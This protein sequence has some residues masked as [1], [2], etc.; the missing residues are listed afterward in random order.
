MRWGWFLLAVLV[1]VLGLWGLGILSQREPTSRSRLRVL[2]P[3]ELLAAASKAVLWEQP[4]GKIALLRVPSGGAW[5]SHPTSHH[6]VLVLQGRGETPLPQESV[7]VGP[8]ELLIVFQGTT[9]EIRAQGELMLLV[10]S[11]PPPQAA[12]EPGGEPRVPGGLLPMRIVLEERFSQPLSELQEGLEGTSVFESPTGSVRLL[13]LRG[14]W[15]P[16]GTEDLVLYVAR[17]RLRVSV[18][19]V[20][21]AVLPGQLLVLPAGVPAELKPAGEADD[22]EV[23]LVSFAL[24]FSPKGLD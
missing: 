10:F 13:R 1:A 16:D 23:L 17:G 15:G 7:T 19:G 22:E 4:L 14:P 20:R 3:E 6:I 21:Y 11:T 2:S 12:P 5:R 9:A 24:P 8:E 18:E